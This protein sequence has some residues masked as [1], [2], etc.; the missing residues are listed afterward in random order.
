[1]VVLFVGLEMIGKVIDSIT[2]KGYL[3][4]GWTCIFFMDLKAINNLFF[5]FCR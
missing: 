3:Y 4:L 1:M 2:Q 5:G